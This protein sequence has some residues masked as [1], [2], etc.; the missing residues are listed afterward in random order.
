VFSG[1]SGFLQGAVTL[2]GF[3]KPVQQN[4]FLVSANY[5]DLLGIRPAA[6]RLFRPD[7]DRI[8]GGNTV[9]VLSYPLAQRLFG[10]PDA[11]VGRAVNLNGMS[12]DVVGVAPAN[13]KGTL[14]FGDPNVA[15]V[16]LS[17]HAQVFAGI[18]EQFFNHRRFRIISTFGRL[19]PGVTDQQAAAEL[20]TVAANLEAAYPGDNRGRGIELAPLSEGA[21]GFPRGQTTAAAIA[22]SAA[23][24]FVLLIA[25]ANVANL[26]LVRAG[27]RSKE[28]G[29]RVALGAP[30]GRLLR[31][32]LTEAQLLALVG[33]LLGLGIGWLSAGALWSF[34]PAFLQQSDL[35]LEIDWRVCL[36]AV[37]ITI[38]TGLLFG[39]APVFRASVPDIARILNSTGRGNIQG[40]GHNRLRSVLVVCEIALALV[41]LAGAGLFIRSMQRAQGIDLGFDTH[42][43]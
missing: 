42:N 22:L 13:F 3:G 9:A 25:C 31:Q 12:Y 29:I 36:F 18:I 30:R 28:M 1:I 24:G 15:W 6:G 7:E 10:R 21:L 38:F 14:T 17:M 16:P 35:P 40:G 4:L 33:G 20:Q 32:L 27:K 26:S 5:F 23:V 11:A 34:R 8:P 37:G 19:K 2:T 39:L 41:A 43:L